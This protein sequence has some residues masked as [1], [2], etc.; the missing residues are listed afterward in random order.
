MKTLFAILITILVIDQSI[1]VNLRLLSQHVQQEIRNN[2]ILNR[3]KKGVQETDEEDQTNQT[4]NKV[5]TA[6]VQVKNPQHDI[7][8]SLDEGNST[9]LQSQTQSN[10]TSEDNYTKNELPDT[11]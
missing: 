6:K 9:S 5:V 11:E 3:D 10:V 7:Q 4:E 2:R 1:Q 8:S